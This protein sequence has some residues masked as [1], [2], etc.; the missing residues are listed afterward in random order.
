MDRGLTDLQKNDKN[1]VFVNIGKGKKNINESIYM[2]DHH[3]SVVCVLLLVGDYSA[4]GRNGGFSDGGDADRADHRTGIGN[5]SGN[6]L[7]NRRN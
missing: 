1:D 5:C 6:C 2:Y 4:K 7:G 3:D